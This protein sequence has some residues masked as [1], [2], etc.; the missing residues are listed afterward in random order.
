MNLPVE[1][2]LVWV[3]LIFCVDIITTIEALLKLSRIVKYGY[4]FFSCTTSG[5]QVCAQVLLFNQD[6]FVAT[7]TFTRELELSLLTSEL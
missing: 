3:R 4:V 6:P 7:G 2:I 1:F 5:H